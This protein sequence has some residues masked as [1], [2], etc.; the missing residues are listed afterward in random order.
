MKRKLAVLSLMVITISS[1][2]TGCMSV[3]TLE[4]KSE[5][6]EVSST[7]YDTIQQETEINEGSMTM[8]EIERVKDTSIAVTATE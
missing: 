3:D 5:F 6:E 1:L 7:A 4:Q 8:E 2:F